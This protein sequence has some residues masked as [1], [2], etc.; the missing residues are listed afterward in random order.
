MSL[1]ISE[2]NKVRE[3]IRIIQ[4]NIE[5][6]ID[7]IKRFRTQ[8]SSTFIITQIEKL[9]NSIEADKSQL[10]I[11]EKRFFTQTFHFFCISNIQ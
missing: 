4:K 10:V 2:K 1:I 5:H 3:S 6:S 11:F 9:E 7:T 8:P